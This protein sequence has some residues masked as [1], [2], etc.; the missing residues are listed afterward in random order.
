MLIKDKIYNN[1]RIISISLQFEIF[2]GDDSP[3]IN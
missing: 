1:F 2:R 3:A